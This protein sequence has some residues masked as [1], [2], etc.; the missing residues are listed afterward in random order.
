[1]SNIDSRVYLLQKYQIFTIIHRIRLHEPKAWMKPLDSTREVHM[2]RF[3]FRNFYSI[4]LV[5]LTFFI[6]Q[7]AS[8]PKTDKTLPPQSDT[9]RPS[10]YAVQSAAQQYAGEIL[11]YMMQVVLGKAGEPKVR[12][13]WYARGVD[14][15]LDF[16]LVSKIMTDPQMDMKRVLVLDNN[17]LG[18]SK[19]LYYYNIRLNLFKGDYNQESL[20][21]SA[22]LLSIRM[23]LLQKI[24]RGE[25]VNMH[26]L[27]QQKAQFMDPGIEAADIDADEIGLNISEIK[28]LKDVIASEPF[29][30]D[31]L[32]NPFVVDTLYRVGVVELDDFV[33]GKISQARYPSCGCQANSSHDGNKIVKIAI[34]PSI[35]KAFEYQGVDK[36]TYDCGFKATDEYIQASQRIQTKIMDTTQQLVKAQMLSGKSQENSN[37]GT[38][39][40]ELAKG[41]A[42]EH[43]EFVNLD[44][45]PFVIYPENANYVMDSICPEADFSIII[46]GEN[47]YLSFNINEVD[48]YPNV[49][50]IYLDI[51]DVRHAQV[52]YELSQV[53][54]F[55]FKK[56]KDMIREPV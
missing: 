8:P 29:F 5:C 49:N 3:V 35:T 45:R 20:F 7:C 26:K 21:P 52:D 12:A 56:L 39:Y 44:K 50:R 53:S 13:L 15:E 30:M 23:M 18:L 32:E 14:N 47:V 27:V 4:G 33:K 54:M 10:G 31:Y 22:E 41:F 2:L 9:T 28:L 25:K 43:V 11:S 38:N 55:I 42:A 51:M 37:T 46:L 17:I 6:L 16:E 19:V 48:I 36:E 24:H 1:M 40:D 34:L